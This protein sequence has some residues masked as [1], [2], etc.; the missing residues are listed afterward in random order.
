MGVLLATFNAVLY[1]DHVSLGT[2]TGSGKRLQ[3]F[4]SMVHWNPGGPP[5][6]P[7][8]SQE[9]LP[10]EIL[11]QF[12]MILSISFWG[13]VFHILLPLPVPASIYGIVIL[14]LVSGAEAPASHR[15]KK[16][17]QLPAPNYAGDVH[18]CRSGA[19]GLLGCGKKQRPS[20]PGHHGTI[21]LCRNGCGRKG[22]PRGH[23]PRKE[24]GG[25][26]R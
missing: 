20:V 21:H 22:N 8:H 11:K 15:R 17:Q 23:S 7:T 26:R 14:F 9:V 18:P 13:E 4:P 1:G 19:D 25:W 3:I 12:G 16:G 2:V 5:A 6:S 10:L 24:A